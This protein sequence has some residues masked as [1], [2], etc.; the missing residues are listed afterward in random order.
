MSV[1]VYVC[2]YVCVL[3]CKYKNMDTYNQRYIHRKMTSIKHRNIYIYIYIY[4][5]RERER[6]RQT[7]NTIDR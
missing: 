7:G 1:C 2:V 6:D 5:E 4:I 3:V